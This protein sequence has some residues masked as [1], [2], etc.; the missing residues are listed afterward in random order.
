M[1]FRQTSSDAIELAE[2]SL[3]MNLSGSYLR[4]K[5]AAGTPPLSSIT[6]YEHSATN[7]MVLLAATVSSVHRLL[8]PHPTVLDKKV[9]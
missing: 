5:V 1:F 8:F 9:Y 4:C 7:Q 3:D 6:I 2:A